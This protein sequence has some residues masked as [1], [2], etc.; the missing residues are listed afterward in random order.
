MTAGTTS[1]VIAAGST[2]GATTTVTDTLVLAVGATSSMED[3][4]AALQTQ[5]N[6]IGGVADITVSLLPDGAFRVSSPTS[7]ITD[8]RIHTDNDAVNGGTASASG[9]MTRLINNRNYGIDSATQGLDVTAGSTADTN[10]FHT[11][12]SLLNSWTWQVAVPHN[13]DIPPSASSGQLVFLSNGN[14]QN[15]GRDSTNNAISSDP[16]IQFDPDGTDPE[17]GGVDSLTIQFN[18]KDLTQNASSTT[19]AIISQDGSPVGRLE[20]IDI[21]NDGIVTGVFSNGTTRT[22]AQILVASF[23]NDGGLMRQGDNMF[24]E[25]SNSGEA[26]LGVP[27]TLARGELASSELELSNVDISE[28][29]VNLILSQRAFQANAR[30][31]TTGDTILQELVNLVR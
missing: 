23:A 1:I 24:S 30:V 17:N 12:N 19:A 4:R 31:I 22:L 20:T 27:G 14:F 21:G 6:T 13:V 25:S 28:E 8:L 29:F 18:F 15:Y 7:T 26:V 3:L 2:I 5:L 9:V 10:T 16:I 11:G